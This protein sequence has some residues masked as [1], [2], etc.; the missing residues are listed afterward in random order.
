M[1]CAP[2]K[3][4]GAL[5]THWEHSECLD[6]TGRVR[7]LI[8]VFAGLTLRF[9]LFVCFFLSCFGSNAMFDA[10]LLSNSQHFTD[11][12]QSIDEPWHV[13]TNKMNVHPAKT[14]ISLGIPP[15]WSESSLYAQWLAKDPSFLHADSEDSD[16]TGR[17]PRLIW[18]FARRNQFVGF[19]MSRLR[20]I[21]VFSS[22]QISLY[23]SRL[24]TKPTK[25]L[26]AQRRCRSAWASAQSDH[27]LR[28]ALNG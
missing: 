14:Q 26:C 4:S 24:M 19:H 3:D 6:Q 13:K 25:W 2:S 11:K 12:S 8:W 16:Q 10:V 28:C 20:C 23:L 15:V 17:M 21:C 7:R 1:T 9:F 18:V 22:Y 27:S 5:G